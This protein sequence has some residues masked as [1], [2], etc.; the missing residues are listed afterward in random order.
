MP[1]LKK[2]TLEEIKADKAATP[3]K[4]SKIE[5]Q[6]NP[7]SLKLELANK[8]DGGETGATQTRQYLGKTSTTLSF[9]L[10]FDTADRGKPGKTP[11]DPGE[12]VSVRTLT[13]AVERF[14]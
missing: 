3:V 4:D 9:D 6:F 13:A 14:V 12:P 10:H 7:A 2:A 8:V 1:P 11:D 5:V